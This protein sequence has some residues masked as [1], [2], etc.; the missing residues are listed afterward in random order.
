MTTLSIVGIVIALL[1]FAVWLL[2]PPRV[3]AAPSKPK[4]P[5]IPTYGHAKS[6]VVEL[7]K[8]LPKAP[9]NYAWEIKVDVNDKGDHVM[10]LG[11]YNMLT[12]TVAVSKS[13]NLTRR[14]YETWAKFYREYENIGPQWF[15]K[16]IIGPLKEWAGEQTEKLTGK[17]D[18][19]NVEYHLET[20]N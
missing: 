14:S 17:R 7:R 10:T 12:S 2:W 8:V 18:P 3:K 4:E 15:D 9:D 11:A 20:G 1:A 5:P 6:P 13:I 16:E 19:G